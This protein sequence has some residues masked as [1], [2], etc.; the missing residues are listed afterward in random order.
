MLKRIRADRR[1]RVAIG[2]PGDVVQIDNVDAVDVELNIICARGNC[3]ATLYNCVARY[4]YASKT[5][6]LAEGETAES[7]IPPRDTHARVVVHDG[8]VA[9]VAL[10][11]DAA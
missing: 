7:V 9:V 2:Y 11:G 4:C 1:R 5:Y 3:S 6:D 10:R 8:V